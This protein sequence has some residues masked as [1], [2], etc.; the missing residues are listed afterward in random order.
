MVVLIPCVAAAIGLLVCSWMKLTS[1]PHCC[2]QC[3]LALTVLHPARQDSRR[4]ACAHTQTMCHPMLDPVAVRR[5]KTARHHDRWRRGC[6]R[7]WGCVAVVVCVAAAVCVVCTQGGRHWDSV[8][9]GNHL[10][11]QSHSCGRCMPHVNDGSM[12][13]AHR[14]QADDGDDDILQEASSWESSNTATCGSEL[15][16]AIM[17]MSRRLAVGSPMVGPPAG[18]KTTCVHHLGDIRHTRSGGSA[19]CLWCEMM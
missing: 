1:A 8:R 6:S 10:A 11:K 19:F 17:A 2:G 12:G 3:D 18:Q 14:A 9:A 5:A 15:S 13:H 4:H 16:C 7:C